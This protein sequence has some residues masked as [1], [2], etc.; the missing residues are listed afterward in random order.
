MARGGDGEFMLLG[1]QGNRRGGGGR[2]TAVRKVQGAKK[3]MP[4]KGLG[5]KRRGLKAARRDQHVCDGGLGT[6]VGRGSGVVAGSGASKDPL[7]LL[8]ALGPQ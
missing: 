3:N 1:T 8:L 6:A 7:G 2:G 5:R 4:E